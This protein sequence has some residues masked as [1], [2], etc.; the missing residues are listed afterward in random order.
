MTS[1]ISQNCNTKSAP[2]SPGIISDRILSG[3][4]ALFQARDLVIDRCIFENGE[5]PLKEGRNLRLDR[6]SFK[7]KYPIWYCRNITVSDS[8]FLEMGRAGIWYTDDITMTG[9]LYEAPKGFR[10]VRRGRITNVRFPNAQETLWNCEDM[11]LENV[12]ARGDY[13]AMNLCRARI[14]G[15][16]LVGNYGFDGARDI[17]ISDSRLLTKDAFW[18][19]E[20]ITIRNSFISGEYF[21]WNSRN[22]TLDN[23]TVDSLQGLCYI[24]GLTLRNCRL[25]GTSLAF[26]YCRNI[27]AD[28]R[29][30]IASI[31]NPESGRITADH[32]GELIL[33]PAKIDPAATVITARNGTLPEPVTVPQEFQA[34]EPS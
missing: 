28:I 21:A 25:P 17:E 4:R 7:W 27:D 32:V 26:E 16:E 10:K 5:S 24:E 15:L 34:K 14:S 20:N 12:T 9:C 1:S 6:V 30:G 23:C 2:D 3:E 11:E 18:N 19:S 8:A 13:F 31:F 33:D 29:G 22:I